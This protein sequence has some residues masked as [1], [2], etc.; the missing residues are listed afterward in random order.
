MYNKLNPIPTVLNNAN[1]MA[2]SVQSGTFCFFG[3][4][5]PVFRSQ[6]P[7]AI[8]SAF[9]SADASVSG[10]ITN[11]STS[12]NLFG[13]LQTNANGLYDLGNCGFIGTI[14]TGILTAVCTQIGHVVSLFAVA[15]EG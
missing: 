1:V 10:L 8:N 14:Y 15:S 2:A 9:D 3:F 11:I 12:A 6:I 13:G 7:L 4:G 5:S